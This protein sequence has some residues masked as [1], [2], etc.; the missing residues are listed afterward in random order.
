MDNS[1]ECLLN[2]R[3]IA[4]VG[5][6]GDER[7][8]GSLPLKFLRDY[9]YTGQ[10]YPVNPNYTEI[11]GY[12]CY[13]SIADVP[14]DVDL[15]VL[16]VSYDQVEQVLV[17]SRPGQIRSTLILSSGYAEIGEV[18]VKR[19]GK[20]VQ[21]A[22]DRGIRL[23]GPNSV[24]IANLWSRVVPSISQAFDS[25]FQ[26]GSIAFVTQSGAL[27]T[28]II[29]LA[30]KIGIHLGYFVSSGNEADLE[31]SDYCNALL[32]DP[33]VEIVAG[34]LEG[35]RDGQKFIQV[36]AKA[37]RMGKPLILIKA[38]RASVASDAARSHTG[39]LTGTDGVYGAIFEQYNIIRVQTIEELLDQLKIM[40]AIPDIKGN[41]ISIV[42][43]SGGSGVLMADGCD[44]LDLSVKPTPDRVKGRLSEVL[45]SY[46]SLNNPVDM[47]ANVIF[48]PDLMTHC[49]EIMLDDDV[50]DVGILGVNL[51]W[52]VR[53]QLVEEIIA[54]RKRM[55]KPFIISWIGIDE[56]TMKALQEGGVPAFGDPGR[57]IRALGAASAWHQ[58]AKNHACLEATQTDRQS[59]SI[60]PLRSIRSVEEQLRVLREYDLKLAP[61]QLVGTYEEAQDVAQSLGF[62]L[63]AKVIAADIAHKSDIGAVIT[64]IQGPTDLEQAFRRLSHIASQH[65]ADGILLQSMIEGAVEIFVGG[66]RDPVFGPTTVIGLG[67]IY[68]EVLKETSLRMATTDLV[69]IEQ[70]IRQQSWQGLLAG[71]R[72]RPYRDIA[73][74]SRIIQSLARLVASTDIEVIDLNPVMVLE[75]GLGAW[76]TDWRI[77]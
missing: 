74:L 63:V 37:Y 16:S 66:R 44:D 34:Y 3:S 25:T 32:E 77:G 12:A 62:P 56:G 21:L 50:Y 10:I 59:V 65:D 22:R 7:K 39:A 4:V 51:M 19:Q 67:G 75:E 61:S 20:L 47:T 24:G 36:A 48:K 6:S 13:R 42:G 28:A 41:N 49:L 46:A 2:P 57:A 27:G 15:L 53:D 60:R 29:A 35:I 40:A 58:K 14:E 8:M 1:L 64:G 38:G 26:P 5:A 18:G 11:G 76:V 33:R 43:H 31:F 73:A 23:C 69:R 17:Q 52:R 30:H 45:P 70:W 68:V 72:G 9:Q 71:A 55:D 54:L